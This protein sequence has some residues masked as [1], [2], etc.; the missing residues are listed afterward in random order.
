[1]VDHVDRQ[2]E[3]AFGVMLT[4]LFAGRLKNWL[5][6]EGGVVV[7]EAM[8]A[9]VALQR[10]LLGLEE[11]EQ[12]RSRLV[13]MHGSVI[14]SLEFWRQL[15]LL[16]PSVTQVTLSDIQGAATVAMHKCQATRL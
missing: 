14:P 16:M 1:M 2:L 4:L 8:A 6:E 9:E 12:G 7:T 13:F 11:E 5:L 10:G 15:V 3:T